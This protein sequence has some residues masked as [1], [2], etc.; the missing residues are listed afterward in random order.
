MKKSIIIAVLVVII[1]L[2]AFITYY[3]NITKI[4]NKASPFYTVSNST[5][6][7]NVTEHYVN[8]TNHFTINYSG[9]A[10]IIFSKDSI[11]VTLNVPIDMSF[12]KSGKLGLFQLYANLT[13]AYN[14]FS[15]FTGAQKEQN[16]MSVVLLYNSSGII[17]CSNIT[18]EMPQNCTF[19]NSKTVIDTI[20]NDL[21]Y[22]LFRSY[23]NSL[24]DT[25]VILN[26]G[27]SSFPVKFIGTESYN[28]NTCSIFDINFSSSN[29]DGSGNLCFSDSVGMPV[30]LD[31]TLNG[32]TSSSSST[33]I[34]SNYKVI[35]KVNSNPI[36][37]SN[38]SIAADNAAGYL[39]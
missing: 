21:E 25:G 18:G 6:L 15:A 13:K 38:I 19:N 24:F 27:N 22:A 37:Y 20:K 2:V 32:Y 39:K 4:N 33:A 30:S 36:S 28:G 12:Q 14:F 31:F 1:I 11:N 10:D 29:A 7:L 5:E 3:Y 23:A 8:I 17:E 16:Y 34:T 9:T 35:F 26:L